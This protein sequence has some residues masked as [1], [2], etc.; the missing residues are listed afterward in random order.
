MPIFVLWGQIP[1]SLPISSLPDLANKS[2]PFRGK[3]FH[4]GYEGY[5]WVTYPHVEN[6]ASLDVD[7]YGKV[8]VVESNRFKYGVQ[9]LR[10]ARYL[11][12]RDFQSRTLEDRL[13]LYKDFAHKIPLDWYTNVPDRVILL[14]DMDGNGVPDR[15][16]VYADDL[17]ETLDGIA[18]SILAERD[19]VYLTSIPSLRKLTDNNN[20][21]IADKHEKLIDG[22]GVRISFTGH[23]LHGVV[24]G[25]DGRLYFSVGDRGYHVT[26]QFGVVHAEPGQ[27]AVF[28]CE[29][30]GSNF[31]VFAYGLR[32]PQELAFDNFGN[33]FTFDNTGD[34]G[35]KARVV[36][37]LE[38]SDSGW[39]MAHQSAHQYVKDLDWGDFHTKQSVWVGE[40]MF[41]VYTEEQPQWVYPPVAHLGN[42]PSGVAW[43]T[44]PSLPKD[45]QN[46]F[47]L[48]D[49][50]GSASRCL[51]HNISLGG[52]GAGFYVKETSSF[53][54]NVGIADVAQGYDGNIYFADFGGGWSVNQ[55]G[56]IQV[57]RP[58]DESLRKK[59]KSLSLLM[60]E[61]F[62]HRSLPELASLLSH[63]DQ[64]VRQASQFAMVKK[65]DDSIDQ[66]KKII[67]D[68]EQPLFAKLHAVWG[69][70]QL[71]RLGNE[72]IESILLPLLTHSEEEIRAN[73]ARVA[74]SSGLNGMAIPLLD[75]MAD[76]SD[77]VVSLTA[78]S[79]GRIGSDNTK[80]IVPK[81][82]SAVRGN[83][84]K[85]FDPV[86][87]HAYISALDRLVTTEDLIKLA[88]SDSV[89]Q[90][91]TSVILLRRRSD[92]NLMNFLEDEEKIVRK[93]AIRAIY[94]TA[95]LDGLAGQKLALVDP[96]D[97][98][99]HIQLRIISSNFRIGTDDSAKRLLKFCS[100]SKISS[101]LK[102]FIFQG[103]L[104][105]GMKLDTDPVLGH[106]R[107]MPVISSS[108]SS[109]TSVLGKDLK[110]FL[111]QKNDPKLVSLAT[112]LAQKIGLS[113]D[114]D[115]LRNQIMN[116]QLDPQVRVANLNSMA[117]LNLTN[118]DT[119]I[120]SLIEDES[121]EVR[122]T[123]FG[124]CIE[125]GLPGIEKLGLSAIEKD[126]LIV[127]RSV[128][129]GLVVKSPDVMID[130][131][132]KRELNLR[133]E[134]W[135]DLYLYLST[136]DHVESQKIAAT[137]AAGEPGRVH[138]LSLYGGNYDSGEKVFRNQGACMQ[139][140]Q[141]DKEGGVQGPSLSLV[142]DRLNPSK[143]LESIVN[144]SAEITPGYGLSS[145]STKDGLT[146]VGRVVNSKDSNGS[147]VLISPDEK[148]TN[149]NKDQIVS[150][151][152]P[153]SAMP[154]LG[155]TLSPSDLR[156]LIAFLKS[157]NKKDLLAMKKEKKSK[158]SHGEK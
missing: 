35:D 117:D 16:T 22:F 51:V 74:G 28:R 97:Y 148:E 70:G 128:M 115:I 63:S 55:N 49:Y 27:G 83:K 94:D 119:I 98:S 75:L 50:R 58:K 53:V 116:N 21:G 126:S 5:T 11:V 134:L 95:A 106:Y 56:S 84:G 152:P 37:V 23:D 18:F 124:H 85:S 127:A 25:P 144:P 73:V 100:S 69:L 154:P 102:T 108:M 104:R 54:G 46:T 34:I 96:A 87:R 7:P 20:D 139:C 68:S 52:K 33:L 141:I 45:L 147:I 122:A 26:D 125:R 59:G 143:L 121:E 120:L 10:G 3:I 19:S 66:F 1:A 12:A 111:M 133:P 40:K 48:T 93:E 8:Y 130:L 61:G 150:I 91:L 140:H 62:N 82:L 132:K 64:R 145:V 80:E 136:N 110:G 41:D 14:E 118:D 81:L 15:R 77:R 131:W 71:A 89:E 88:S 13:Q 90:R 158:L 39:D 24:R 138:A 105:W 149:L 79:L 135:L 153:V 129:K 30:N 9:D 123:S 38:N 76:S 43:I 113:M 2:T 157:R 47:L 114:A 92:S 137:Y 36:Y 31:E 44:G 142:G 32:N 146:L 72:K 109:L 101:D 57:I 156:D 6:S 99:Y 112:N 17:N 60:A 86:L 29:S 78:L 151:S 65:G 67:E 107:P 42:G 155:L 4:S 103:L